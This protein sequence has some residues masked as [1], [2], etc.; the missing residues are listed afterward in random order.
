MKLNSILA[1]ALLAL[2]AAGSAVAAGNPY[3]TVGTENPV[4]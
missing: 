1:A 4:T 2:S 3:P